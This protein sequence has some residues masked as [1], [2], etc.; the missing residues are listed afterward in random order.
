[1]N[2]TSHRKFDQSTDRPVAVDLHGGKVCVTLADG[3]VISTPLAGHS[4][5]M[6]ATPEQ[7][8]NFELDYVS[9]WW[10]DLDE[11]LDIEWMLREA[12]LIQE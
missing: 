7:R 9:V 5:L 6:N 1:M 2:G 8:A 10:P 11:G 3:Q 4:W 12:G